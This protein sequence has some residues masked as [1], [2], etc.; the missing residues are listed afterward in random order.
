MK[1]CAIKFRRWEGEKEKE[2]VVCDL[3]DIRRGKGD[4]KDQALCQI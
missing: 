4:K 2:A 1:G 3:P